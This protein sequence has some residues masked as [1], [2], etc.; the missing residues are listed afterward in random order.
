MHKI[1]C[2]KCGVGLHSDIKLKEWTCSPCHQN[3]SAK[4]LSCIICS[5]SNGVFIPTSSSEWLHL[6]CALLLKKHISP[7]STLI[8]AKDTLNCTI[9]IEIPS[10]L[11]NQTCTI[12]NKSSKFPVFPCANCKESVHISCVIQKNWKTVGDSIDCGCLDKKKSLKKTKIQELPPVRGPESCIILEKIMEKVIKADNL[13]LFREYPDVEP[14]YKESLLDSLSSKCY[15]D[16]DSDSLSLII[17]NSHIS[18]PN[19]KLKLTTPSNILEFEEITDIIGTSEPKH[20]KDYFQYEDE[21]LVNLDHMYNYYIRGHAYFSMS[22]VIRDLRKIILSKL[23]LSKSLKE[24]L[25]INNFWDFSINHLNHNKK[26]FEDAVLADWKSALDT[27]KQA[28]RVAS[29]WH[30][31]PFESRTYEL[32]SEYK[33][34]SK[35]TKKRL[36]TKK[37][38][39]CDGSIC[40]SL[41]ELGPF[42]LISCAWDSQNPDRKSRVECSSDCGCDQ[43][44]CKNRQISLKQFQKLGEDVN[45]VPTW[46][47]DVY[48][49]RNIM[50]YLRHPISNSNKMHKFISHVLPKAINSG[51]KDNW[52]ILNALEYILLD[53]HGIFTLRNKRYAAGLKNAVLGLGELIGQNTVL[54]EFQIHP[55][56]TG[57]ICANPN[58][59]CRNSLIVE[60]FGQ[61][62]SPAKWYEKQDLIKGI[63][64]QMKKKEGVVDTLPD[65]Y[66]IMMERH[67]DD[68]DGYDILIVD[69]IFYG[70][71]GS[72]LS[73]SCTPNCGTVTMVAEG[74]YSIGMYALSDIN[75][76]DELTFDYNS[77]TE[78]REEHLNAVCL[79]ASSLC[80]FFYLAHAQNSS[81][82]PGFHNFLHRASLMVKAS[83]LK[84]TPEFQEICEKFFIRAAVLDNCP[85]WLKVWI[86]LVLKVV[87]KESSSIEM[88]IYKKIAIDSRLQNLVMTVDKVK[89]CMERSSDHEPYKIL[90][91]SEVIEYLWGLNET[92]IRQ[93]VKKL[94]QDLGL[95]FSKFDSDCSS[96]K[97][98]KLNILKL[99]DVLRKTFPNKWRGQG[100]ADILHLIAYT[101]V[102]FT[103]IPYLAFES[104]PVSIR[105]CE[106][107]KATS[108]Y[109]IFKSL[110][111]KYSAYHIHGTLCGWYKQTVDKPAA[112]LSADKRGTLS[113]TCIENPVE[114]EYTEKI[115][116]VLLEHLKERPASSWPTKSNTKYPWGNFTNKAKIF[117][118]PMFDSSFFDDNEIINKTLAE[119]DLPA[120]Q[121]EIL[122]SFHY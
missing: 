72:R 49:Y 111:K 47:F 31:E 40:Y 23:K 110:T 90:I 115:R 36:R 1:I 33:E 96:V 21:K 112:S 83:I 25:Y 63:M 94:F 60:Y 67:H 116:S 55:K 82:I 14:A 86:A 84:F 46:G 107:S 89:Y 119:I 3:I 38:G 95:D 27:N 122:G 78:S 34:V 93:Q 65:F 114:G 17:M 104:D 61:L 99:K 29:Q 118:T 16:H 74:R 2:D 105:H 102:Y 11:A 9:S 32:I 50:A 71:F 15:I 70:S 92:S 19:K 39:Q 26:T 91:E 51:K 68:P 43:F 30:K 77:I 35:K 44:K 106:V 117:G 109:T 79:C 52:S 6:F 73:H 88:E 59:I 80:R 121:C 98:A 8:E 103:E 48:T 18:L 54:N 81:N 66:N 108:N 69:P 37:S 56:G 7:T 75:Y 87:E 58:G 62:Y 4:S 53:E 28:P 22:Q 45:E 64:N 24:K 12:C 100:I 97:E 57:V 85:E 41:P 101:Q 20:I 120:D 13:M 10:E 113:V 42:D 5:L 76:L